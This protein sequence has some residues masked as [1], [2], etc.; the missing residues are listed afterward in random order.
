MELEAGPVSVLFFGRDDAETDLQDGLLKGPVFRPTYAYREALSGRK[1]LIIGR[2]G[3]G[4]SAICR[5]LATPDGHPGASVLI[6]PDDAAGDE[7]RRFALRDSPPTRPS[8]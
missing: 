6:A 1:S 4:K 2:K 3:S 5:Q 7:I 8:R